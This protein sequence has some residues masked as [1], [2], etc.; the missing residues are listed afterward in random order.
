MERSL[1]VG[2]SGLVGGA[3]LRA[4]GDAGV[5]TYRTRAAPHL[6]HLDAADDRAVRSALVEVG[7]RVVFFPAAEPHVDWCEEHPEGSRERNVVPA[8]TALHACRDAGASFVFF[9]T[10]Y[11]F[12]GRAGPYAETDEPRPLSVFGRHKRE[13]ELAV[14][15][16]G[17]TVVRT[18]T[19]FGIEPPPG[20]NFVLRLVARLRAGERVPVPND[21]VATPTWADELAIGTLAVAGDG[22]LWNVAGPDLLARDAFAGIVADVFDVDPSGIDAVPTSTLGQRAPRPLAGGLRTEKLSRRIGR[23]LLGARPSLERLRAQLAA[24]AAGPPAG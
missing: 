16:A 13:I 7:P 19:V 6:R 20:K 8:L 11:V 24:A 2:A 1:V 4:L 5:G 21:Q 22:G 14:L 15:D 23:P 18:T 17:G 3:L 9:S 12:D 10:D